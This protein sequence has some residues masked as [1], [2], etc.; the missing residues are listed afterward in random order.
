M[1]TEM[2]DNDLSLVSPT[3]NTSPGVEYAAHTRRWQGIPGIE[4]AANGRL[5]AVWYSGGDTEGPDNYVVLVTS[6][7]N[8]QTWSTPRVVIDPPGKVRAYDPALWHDP[9][10]RLWL[11][12]AQSYDWYDG[13]AGVWAI[14][15]SDSGDE[16]PQWSLPR[17]LANGIMMN[18]PTFL[19]TG[20][21]LLPTAVWAHM[22][23]KMRDELCDECHSNVTCS[24]DQ[25]VSWTLLG[26]ADVPERQ[27]DE[28]M[29]VER[30][31]GSL[32]MLVRTA[33]GVGESIS[34]DRGRTWEKS[35]GTVIAGPNSRFFIRR[36][37]SGKLLLVNH[38]HF[39][40]RNN[41][42]AMLSDDDGA[43]WYGHLMLDERNDVSYPDGAQSADGRIYL[44]YDHSRYG[45][46]EILM[47]SITEDDIAA[48]KIINPTSRLRVL[49][50]KVG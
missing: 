21:W 6:D 46:K 20:E 11:S 34:F 31:D 29:V 35:P 50:N 37:Q 19:S 43:S 24:K 47:A 17:R 18:K 4:I 36:L 7:D 13:R 5:W 49:V 30:N 12:W 2:R 25:G 39:T 1:A 44:I 42:T 8:G 41:L 10:G 32:W 15:T 38:Y 45:D 48:G 9:L 33:T 26:G 40:G 23:E 16:N 28:H 14:C 3:I 22:P 27:F